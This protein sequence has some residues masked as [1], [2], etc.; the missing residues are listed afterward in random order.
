MYIILLLKYAA[1]GSFST[2]VLQDGDSCCMFGTI[3]LQDLFCC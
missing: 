1:C 2:N 3:V